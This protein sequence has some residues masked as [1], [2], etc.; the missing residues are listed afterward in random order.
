MLDALRPGDTLVVWRLDRLSRS[1]SD[2]VQRLAWLERSHVHTISICEALDTTTPAGLMVAH[3]IGT[4]AEFERA[5]ILERTRAGL[6]SARA[7]GRIGGRPPKLAGDRLALLLD[8]LRAGTHRGA[9]LARMFDVHPSQISRHAARLRVATPRPLTEV[10]GYLP[11]ADE[12]GPQ[13]AAGAGPPP[14]RGKTAPRG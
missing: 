12:S 5:I 2:L 13:P 14:R 8:L 3:M 11:N 9:D 10:F 6:D 7:R 4:F 1:L